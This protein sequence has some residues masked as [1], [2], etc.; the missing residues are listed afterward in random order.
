MTFLDIDSIRSN[1]QK[2]EKL[3]KRKEILLSEA[4]NLELKDR[5]SCIKV[6]LYKNELVTLE[7][8]REEYEQ[9]KHAIENLSSL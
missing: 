8:K 3:S 1:L 7:Q 6:S 2:H 5:E 4:K 9:N